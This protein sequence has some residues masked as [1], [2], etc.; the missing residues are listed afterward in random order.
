ME[1]FPA[2]TTLEAAR[3]QMEVFR[4]MTPARRLQLAFD[5]S[6]S[7]RRVVASGIRSRHPEYTEEQ[8]AVAAAARLALGDDLFRKAYPGVEIAV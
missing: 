6:H 7:L 2:D 4:R 1:L 5:M 8:V 3:V